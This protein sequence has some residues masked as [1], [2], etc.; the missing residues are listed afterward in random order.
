MS[1]SGYHGASAASGAPTYSSGWVATTLKTNPS[2]LEG[3]AGIRIGIFPEQRRGQAPSFD[4]DKNLVLCP[5]PYDGGFMELFYSTFFLVKMFLVSDAR[6]PKPDD[7]AYSADRYV[8]KL[9][10]ERRTVPVLHVIDALEHLA[11]P[12]LLTSSGAGD[13]YSSTITSAIAP[14]ARRTS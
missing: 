14:V 13:P 9:L 6:V 1:E 10:E 7:L 12:G 5:V 11:Q 3:D 2:H 8:A 4:R